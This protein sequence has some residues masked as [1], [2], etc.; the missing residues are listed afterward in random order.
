MDDSIQ[1]RGGDD[2][3]VTASRSAVVHDGYNWRPIDAN[4][5]R[6]AKLQL[7][8]K[9]AGVAVYGTLGTHTTH[10]THWAPLPSWGGT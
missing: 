1:L 2:F 3:R 6:G 10:W 9:R 4:T 5:P 8:N 7:I